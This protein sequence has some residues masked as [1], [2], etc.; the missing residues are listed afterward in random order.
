MYMCVIYPSGT[1]RKCVSARDP[2]CVWDGDVNQ[3]VSNPFSAERDST[4]EVN[5]SRY[6]QN[7]H[8]GNGDTTE[9]MGT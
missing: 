2:Y 8:S 5:S 3:C 9:C 1:H 7:V 6:K 4:T